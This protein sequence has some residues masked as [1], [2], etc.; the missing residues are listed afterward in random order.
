ME[1]DF[2]CQ[3]KGG[4]IVVGPY[5]AVGLEEFPS[6]VAAWCIESSQRQSIPWSRVV[7]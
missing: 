1:I 5:I 6:G 4:R 2:F 7:L 3:P